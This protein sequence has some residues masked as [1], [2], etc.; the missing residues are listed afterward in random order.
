MNITMQKSKPAFIA[1]CRFSVFFI[2]SIFLSSGLGILLRG[3]VTKIWGVLIPVWYAVSFGIG[4]AFAIKPQWN[5][6]KPSLF[7][8]LTGLCWGMPFY[9]LAV[10]QIYLD[11]PLDT[12]LRIAIFVAGLGASAIVVKPRLVLDR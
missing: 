2:A 8:F 12:I 11:Q 9:V 5:V 3:D 10:A 4:I 1:I 7:L 6:R